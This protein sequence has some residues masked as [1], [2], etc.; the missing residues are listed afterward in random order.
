MTH[1]AAIGQLFARR[2]MHRHESDL[3]SN[4]IFVV[5]PRLKPIMRPSSTPIVPS[6]V[7]LFNEIHRIWQGVK[8]QISE[9]LKFTNISRRNTLEL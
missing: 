9:C 5:D 3:Q 7:K 2:V 8:E 1:L 4:L 6:D